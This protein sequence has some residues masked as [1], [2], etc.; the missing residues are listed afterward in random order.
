MTTRRQDDSPPAP[1]V[2]R[3]AKSQQARFVVVGGI[4]T[5]V[6][7][8]LYALFYHFVLS[9]LRLGY[10]LS[11]IASYTLSITLAF[12][13]Y[14]RFVFPTGGR[15][16]RDFPVFVGVNLF[17]IVINLVL[18]AVSVEVLGLTP[19]RAQALALAVTTTISYFGHRELSFRPPSASRGPN[20]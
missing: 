20:T 15:A 12:F 4:N 5:V 1:S 6:G 14:R 16:T 2:L 19:F 3:L 9:G 10:L 7:Y 17:A 13:L 8:G 18:L 11:L